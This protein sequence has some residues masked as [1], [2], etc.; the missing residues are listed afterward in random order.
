M[1]CTGM[2]TAGQGAGRGGGDREEFLL[3]NRNL[4]KMQLQSAR[5]NHAA[6]G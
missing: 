5:Y 3:S 1:D 2:G 6:H 4:K